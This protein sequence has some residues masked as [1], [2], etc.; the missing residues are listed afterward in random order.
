ML[1]EIRHVDLAAIAELFA[2]RNDR[3]SAIRSAERV[4]PPPLA[5]RLGE[6]GAV[7]RSLAVEAGTEALN[8]GQ[9]AAIL[10]AGGQG[11][12]LGFSQPKGM[13][14][15]GPISGRTLFQLL[16]DLLR[17]R[18][19][20][21]RV[22]IPLVVMT[23]PATHRETVDY[24]SHQQNLGLAHDGI[25]IICQGTMP[26]VD[27]ATGR[28][29]MSDRHRLSLS[30]D[31]H[32]GMLRALVGGGALQRLLQRG[33]RYLFYAQIDNPLVQL[34]DPA[35]LG[36]HRRS[37]AEASTQV[38]RKQDP[39]QRVG[40][41][42]L[43]DGRLQV[44]EYSDLPAALAGLR[45]PN[46]QL[47]LWAGNIAVH[48]F[49]LLF[50]DRVK[51]QADALPFHVALKRVPYVDPRGQ[52]IQ[53][54]KPNGLKFERFIFDLLPSA[55]LAI[56][57]EIDPADGFSAVKNDLEAPTENV[58][59]AQAAMVAQ[60]TR[61]L[62]S[63]GAEVAAGTPIEIHPEFALDAEQLRQK[64]EPGRKFNQPTYLKP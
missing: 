62:A 49:N 47:R 20:R 28:I 3:P 61:W 16:T 36:Y 56:V 33:I 44:I 19:A 22:Q 23:S 14:P 51:D 52:R 29:L 34:C 37:G 42:V 59:T 54:S 53:P 63:C 1:R 50:L 17:A 6:A 27:A 35:M 26:A 30:P 60:H 46:G 45:E 55:Q 18:M 10:V 64:I 58:R 24:F 21:H 38:V 25:E 31:G 40:N 41:V 12:R 43:L 7:D 39:L 15:V 9:V 13:L 5:N 48:V 57:V 4:L 2:N 11:T 32:G 8:A